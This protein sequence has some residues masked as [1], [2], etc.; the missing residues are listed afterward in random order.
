[1]HLYVLDP[2]PDIA[3]PRMGVRMMKWSYDSQYLATRRDDVPNAVYIWSI[4][5][6]QLKVVLVHAQPVRTFEWSSGSPNRLCIGTAENKVFLWDSDG[7]CVVDVP[8][9]DLQVYRVEWLPDART[10]LLCDRVRVCFAYLG[11]EDE[12]SEGHESVV[13]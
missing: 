2:K 7:A 10:V 13:S 1:M 4:M 6:L 5:T 12:F 3:F 9:E 11:D 8:M